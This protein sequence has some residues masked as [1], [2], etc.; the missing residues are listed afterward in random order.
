MIIIIIVYIVFTL[1]YAHKLRHTILIVYSI[2]TLQLLYNNNNDNNNNV[3]IAL[4]E[5]F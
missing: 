2:Q 5:K 1:V 4:Y 3:F